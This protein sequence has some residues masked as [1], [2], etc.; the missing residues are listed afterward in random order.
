MTEE[1]KD[2]ELMSPQNMRPQFK[3]RLDFKPEDKVVMDQISERVRKEIDKDFGP[4][5]RALHGL[6]A[7]VRTPQ[8]IDGQIQY[9]E[10]GGY[11]WEKNPDGSMV[12]HWENVTTEELETYI[13]EASAFNVWAGS[14]AVDY[15]A[16]GI[17]A[18]YAQEDA[19]SEAYRG[20][21]GTV[22]SRE[23]QAN[24]MTLEDKYF[25]F[26]LA[27]R[28]A[29]L[30]DLLKRT[31]NLVRRVENQCKSRT[32]QQRAEGRSYETVV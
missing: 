20:T 11:L 26:Y 28:S 4:G 8:T 9:D 19:F 30:E 7:K 22:K 13:T 21:Q 5:Y 31:D 25:S 17:F 1:F 15:K 3:L 32:W 29:K 14:I 24:L 18:K 2:K 27:W 10:Y 12:E 16:M 23:Q 6:Y